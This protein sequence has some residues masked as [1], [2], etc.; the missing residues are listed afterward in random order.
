MCEFEDDKICGWTITEQFGFTWVRTNALEIG[1]NELPGPHDDWSGS[2]EKFFLNSMGGDKAGSVTY[3]Q[4][5]NFVVEEHKYECLTF[6][7]QFGV[8]TKISFILMQRPGPIRTSNAVDSRTHDSPCL[9][10]IRQ[11]SALLI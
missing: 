4:T 8:I 7:F 9:P 2:N 10:E 3:L 6:W 11:C 1:T 5:E